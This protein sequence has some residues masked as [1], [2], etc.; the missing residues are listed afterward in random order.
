VIPEEVAQRFRVPLGFVG[1]ALYLV[2]ARPTPRSFLVGVLTAF[3]GLL[4]RAW[5]AGHIIKNERLAT[6]GPYAFTRNPLYL[7]S[8]LLAA[9]FA[10]AGHFAFLP[11]VVAFFA[12]IYR[13]T[14]RRERDQLAVRYGAA[15]EAYARQVPMFLPRLS[16]WS[17]EAGEASESPSFSLARYLRH[18]EWQAALGFAAAVLFLVWRMDRA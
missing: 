6:A 16:P 10:I 1:A 5:A 12:L 9:G 4:V 8:F 18:R 3:V 13:P 14:M 17:G 7:G 15:Y 11:F 2:L